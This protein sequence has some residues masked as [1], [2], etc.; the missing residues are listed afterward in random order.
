[1]AQIREATFAPLQGEQVTGAGYEAGVQQPPW[2]ALGWEQGRPWARWG[3]APFQT[4]LACLPAP[5]LGGER[6][7]SQIAGCYC[8][9]AGVASSPGGSFCAEGN[10]A[11]VC[12]LWRQGE[13]L[14][15]LLS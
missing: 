2:R 7:R 9:L 3:F 10:E 15:S 8:C 1:M 11:V 6:P 4:H 5:R 14:C 13:F 12:G